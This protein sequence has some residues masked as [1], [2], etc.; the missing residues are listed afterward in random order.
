MKGKP[1]G[2][3]VLS[4]LTLI[5]GSALL[6]LSIQFIAHVVEVTRENE[7]NAGNKFISITKHIGYG[8]TFG[9]VSNQFS[10]T[11]LEAMNQEKVFEEVVPVTSN[12][13]EVAIKGNQ[14]L[15]FYSELFLQSVPQHFIDIDTEG[16]V[17]KEGEEVPIILSSHFY[18]LYNHGFAPSQGL[19]A[20]PKSVLLEKSFT[21]LLSGRKGKHTIRCKVYG[22]SDRI[23][24]L[25]VPQSFLEWGNKSLVGKVGAVTMVMAKVTDP[26]SSALKNYLNQKGLVVN[27]EQLSS[28]KARMILTIVLSS[29]AS[30]SFIVFAVSLLQIISFTS[31]VLS[32]NKQLVFTLNLMGY[33]L[34]KISKSVFSYFAALLLLSYLFSNLL[35]LAGLW[36]MK[37]YLADF[38]F[39]VDLITWPTVIAF[40]TLPMVFFV[41]L[42]FSIEAY[43]KKML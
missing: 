6:L 29:F 27:N 20:L 4:L 10:T 33:E 41:H 36:L 1:K 24:S 32:E 23:S 31:L 37:S 16:F 11:E 3:L 21:L 43:L 2:R 22:F 26:A 38:N 5:V 15:P 13:F 35:V 19:P 7:K 9:L 8:N 40:L 30:L 12:A 42:Y 28:D 14:F 34:K 39:E 25:I 18:N 17:W